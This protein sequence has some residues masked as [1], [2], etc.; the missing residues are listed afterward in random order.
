MLNGMCT[1]EM[2]ENLKSKIRPKCGCVPF[3]R[4]SDDMGKADIKSALRLLPVDPHDLDLLGMCVDGQFYYDRCMPMG[5]S[6]SCAVFERFST[7]LQFCCRRVTGSQCILHYLD[8]FFF[9]GRSA[10]E[11]RRTI[12]IAHDKTEGPFTAITYLDTVL[13]QIRVPRDMVSALLMLLHDFLSKSRVTLRQMQSLIGSLHVV[14]KAIGPDRAFLRRLINLTRGVRR[15][16]HR[17]RLTQGAKAD[18]LAWVEFLQHFNGTVGIAEHVWRGNDFFHFY[19]DAAASIGF[20]IYLDVTTFPR[21]VS[22]PSFIVVHAG[23]NDIGLIPKK[24]I[25]AR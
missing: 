21:S 13:L 16:H 22:F 2:I 17:I 18:L 4:M 5:C 25:F 10:A 1:I 20:G 19:T 15:H 14:C 12:P 8:N 6:V 3:R 7:F 24:L 23:T 11:C 9:A